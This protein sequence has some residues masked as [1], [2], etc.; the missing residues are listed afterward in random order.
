VPEIILLSEYG[1]PIAEYRGHGILTLDDGRAP[2]CSFVAG[3]LS[4]GLV[5]ILC[6][7]GPNFYA[8]YNSAKHF[9]GET[10]DGFRVH[11][12]H[13]LQGYAFLPQAQVGWP[14]AFHTKTLIV[15]P[16]NATGNLQTLHFGL[17]NFEF[18]ASEADEE[19]NGLLLSLKLQSG[20][21]VTQLQIIPRPNYDQ[22]MERVR[23]LRATDVVCEA[24]VRIDSNHSLAAVT[25]T[26]ENLSHLMS[27]ARG[28]TVQ[29]VYRD[30]YDQSGVLTKREHHS[31]ITRHYSPLHIFPGWYEWETKSFLENQYGPYVELREPYMLNK[32]MISAYLE[33]KAEDDLIERRSIKLAV[34]VEMLKSIV[35]ENAGLG[36]GEFII[37][38]ALFEGLIPQLKSSM[39]QVL[40]VAKV[41]RQSQDA[42]LDDRKLKGLNRR[43]FSGI[44]RKL[45]KQI[46]FNVDEA[47]LKLFIACRNS[48]LHRGR[49]YCATASN[50]DRRSCAPPSSVRDEYF[51]LVSFVDRIVLKLLRYTGPYWDWRTGRPERQELT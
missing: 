32:G 29:W 2:E 27:V 28:T 30:H 4:D 18:T 23:V 44:L 7:F 24:V 17:T 43:S 10:P 40:D 25:D 31:R 39:K 35:I 42:I 36:I 16:P 5:L 13:A 33:A 46:G 14:A 3:Q 49:F 26:I 8:S 15:E 21:D 6:E 1:K 50:E 19:R 48:L 9:Q 45:R 41:D 47:E 37:D 22:I 20:K 34:A 11:T 12:E 38:P 51:F